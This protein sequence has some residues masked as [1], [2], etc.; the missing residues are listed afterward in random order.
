MIAQRRERAAA[1]LG[2]FPLKTIIDRLGRWR[3]V[4][5]LNYHRVGDGSLEPWDRALWSA[6]ADEL[7]AQLHAAAR[8]ADVIDP[9]ELVDAVHARSGRRLMLTFDDGYRDNYEIAFPVL[10]SHGVRAAFFLATGFLDRPKAPWW[11][12][13]AWMVNHATPQVIETGDWFPGNLSLRQSDKQASIAK[14]VAHYKLLPDTDGERFLEHVAQATGSGRCPPECAAGLWMT[15]DMARDLRS[16]GM[17]IGGHTVT[18]PVLA[19]L[20]ADRQ[21]EEI[22]SCAYRLHDELKIKMTSFA[23][24]VGSPDTFTDLTKR[25]LRECE[26]ET[27]FS[28]HGGYAAPSSM[29][30]LAVPRI[31]IGPGYTPQMLQAAAA[32]P[33]IFARR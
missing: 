18:H 5:I 3:G 32:L 9:D 11:D 15:W 17:S 25:I 7:D 24:P 22:A 6:T 26:V 14:L 28:F 2:H 30:P 16:A 33:Q 4:L 1:L 27:A 29:D 12:E 13:M 10:R 31:H 19:R 20:S 23:Y 8:W 21:R